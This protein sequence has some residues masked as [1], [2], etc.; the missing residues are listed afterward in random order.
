MGNSR[1]ARWASYVR[2]TPV[3]V[4]RGSSKKSLM[5]GAV[6]FEPT[7]P[8]G[9]RILNPA[10]RPIPPRSREVGWGTRTRTWNTGV[11]NQGDAIS[12]CPSTGTSLVAAH[13]TSEMVCVQKVPFPQPGEPCSSRELG[14]GFLRRVRHLFDH[15]HAYLLGYFQGVDIYGHPRWSD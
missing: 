7:R 13:C 15:R 14:E 12:L 2:R 8:E 6:G 10:R 1:P 4:A 11:K 9:H 5:V 3:F